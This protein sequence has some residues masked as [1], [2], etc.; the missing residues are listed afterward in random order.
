MLFLF[1]LF[2]ISTSPLKKE[3]CEWLGYLAK[4]NN[5]MKKTSM[6]HFLCFV[7]YTSFCQK[8]IGISQ[9]VGHLWSTSENMP[10]KLLIKLNE[11][12]ILACQ[13]KQKWYQIIFF[14]LS[15]LF[16]ENIKVFVLLFSKSN[17]KMAPLSD[18]NNTISL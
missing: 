6:K 14:V 5:K 11:K 12:I 17:I 9:R 7:K 10:R 3:D 15:C 2:E 4:N 16:G 1:L 13:S 18:Q 8:A